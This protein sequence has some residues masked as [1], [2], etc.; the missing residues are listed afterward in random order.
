M[1]CRDVSAQKCELKFLFVR[2]NLERNPVYVD[3]RTHVPQ[4]NC[5]R[6]LNICVC[7]P[8]PMHVQ[9]LNQI[10]L[11]IHKFNPETSNN[12]IPQIGMRTPPWT[13][14]GHVICHDDFS[15]ARHSIIYSTF[16]SQIFV[17]LRTSYISVY[18][19]V[20]K[21]VLHYYISQLNLNRFSYHPQQN[22]D[23]TK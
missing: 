11:I 10:E 18:Q 8:N 5:T 9:L 23:R 14:L 12:F 6:I 19:A 7:P 22:I 21:L 13:F 15:D 3:R 16:W 20:S 4:N 1:K 17:R 2:T